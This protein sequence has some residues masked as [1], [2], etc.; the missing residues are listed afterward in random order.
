MTGKFYMSF[1]L[2]VIFKSLN[3]LHKVV[4]KTYERNIG[5]HKGLG[6]ITKIPSK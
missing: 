6:D 2:D 3:F 5:N 4:V 1:L